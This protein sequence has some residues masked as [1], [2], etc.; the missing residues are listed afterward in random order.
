[1]EACQ[2]KIEK[3]AVGAVNAL[4]NQVSIADPCIATDDKQILLDGTIDLYKTSDQ[5]K[6]TFKGRID[7]Q[8]KGTS[9]TL[10]RGPK[11]EVKKP[12]SVTDLKRYRDSFHGVLFFYVYT[13][14]VHGSG[15][16]DEVFYA[17]L[18]PYDITRILEDVSPSQKDVTVAF[19]PFPLVP[20]EIKRLLTTFWEEKEKQLK[21]RV[22][23]HG[24]TI[25]DLGSLEN[26]ES[27][28]F[29][30]Q[31]YPDEPLANLASLE[32]EPY[33]YAEDKSGLVSVVSKIQGVSAVAMGV[34]AEVCSGNYVAKTTVYCGQSEAGDVVEFAG[35]KLAHAQDNPMV[36]WTLAGSVRARYNTALLVHEMLR[37]NA[38]SING[39]YIT[40]KFKSDTK[41]VFEE[42]QKTLRYYERIVKAMDVLHVSAD[43]DTSLMSKKDL[44][45]IN[46][47]YRLLVERVPYDGPELLSPLVRFEVQGGSAYALA[48]K[49]DDGS[50]CFVDLNS[51]EC[52]FALGVQGEE[53][54]EPSDLTDPV[55]AFMSLNKN[56]F[57]NVVNLSPNLFSESIERYPVRPSTLPHLVNKLLDLLSAYDEGCKQPVEVLAVAAILSRKLLE[58]QPDSDV[59]YLNCLQ[60]MKRRRKLTRGEE[61][62]LRTIAVSESPSHIKAAAFA[63]LGE[64][65]NA[66]ACCEKCSPQELAD[67]NESPISLFLSIDEG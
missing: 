16:D 60:T 61:C 28:S 5:K 36:S 18:L 17:R 13:G 37:T 27:F 8:V 32:V 24:F 56:D 42:I 26:I 4:I 38:I 62:R 52:F 43:W 40:L 3:I 64:R 59:F 10:K 31:I 54:R 41:E 34:K 53:V 2:K 39:Y 49:G 44:E 65:E 55:P 19:K 45:T 47:I 57:M 35:I 14:S 25:E 46:S 51:D 23:G 30:L 22:H 20:R 1:M 50:Y 15:E 29:S 6:E 66:L 58:A 21:A 67:L 48:Y 12:V 7:V 63:L 11:G 9:Q 33:V